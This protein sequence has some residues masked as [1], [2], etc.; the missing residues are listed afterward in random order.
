M[1]RQLTL[2]AFALV[3]IFF[4]LPNT[5]ASAAPAAPVDVI[6]TQPDG[7]TV[8]VRPFGDE[9]A[10][11]YETHDG[12]VVVPDRASGYWHY[13]EHDANQRFV[14]SGKRPGRDDPSGLSK[15][16][17]EKKKNRN[18]EAMSAAGTSGPA[19]AAGAP[20][21]LGFSALGSQKVLVI[22]AQFTDR[23]SVGSTP[24]D[25]SNAFFG[26]GNS[27]RRWY[28]EA[29]YGKF[30]FAPAETTGTAAPG[31]AGWVT[32]P[33]PHP[34]TGGSTDDRNRK[35]VADAI[36]AAN[37]YI[38]Y[39]AFDTNRNG[40]ISYNE[41]H[42]VVVVA[43]YETAYG[44]PASACQ[45]GIW[46]HRWGLGDTVLG[47]SVDGVVVGSYMGGGGYLQIG[48]WQCASY[49]N[50]GHMAT[51]GSSVHEL[52]H[53]IGWP[54]LYDVDGSTSGVGNWDI[55]AG[56]GWA[57]TTGYAGSLPTHPD[58]FLRWYQGWLTPSQL[59]GSA[60]GL[61]L[62]QVETNA[63]VVQLL[64]NP[65]GIDWVFGSRSGTGEYYLM[66]N[67]QKV[68]FDAGLPGAGM[69]IWHIDESVTSSNSANANENHRLVDVMQADGLRQL[70][71]TTGRGDAGDPYPGT[72]NN[73]SFTDTT[74]PS[75]RLYSGAAS[76]VSVTNI[77]NSG[78]TMSA[79]AS[80]PGTAST[81]TPT[82]T[83]PLTT[84]PTPTSTPTATP[85][86][87][88]ATTCPNGQYKAEYF[89]NVTMSGTPAL[90]RCESAPINYNWGNGSPAVGINADRFSVR[91]TGTFGFNA[92]SYNFSATADDGV[93]LLVDGVRI[94]DAWYDQPPT[95]YTASRNM[96]AGDYS[97]VVEYY[98]NLIGAVA[99]V[100][101]AQA[102][103]PTPT[104]TPTAPPATP[105][106]TSTSVS[107]PTPTA[108]PSPSPTAS[109]GSC[110]LGQYKAEYFNNMTL[111]GT[112]VL[113]RCESSIN[114]DWGAGSPAAGIPADRFSV[115]WTGQFSFTAG[116]RNF[117]ATADD[118]VR[119]SV[120]GSRLIE[121]WYDQGPT[122]YVTSRNMTAGTHTVMVEYYEDTGGAVAKV[123]W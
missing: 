65:G 120:D 111:S 31:V 86:A 54:D 104:A 57:R 28:E 35:I 22:L 51:I 39:A 121:A 56:G 20:G 101:W 15:H 119:L 87:P 33:Y 98:E 27:V 105:T 49:D 10:N 106:P 25:W 19:Q 13:A 109:A 64:D 94:I 69:L 52:G 85:T 102:A 6:L 96:T 7:T 92:G 68:G 71:T 48:E 2:V 108:S 38:N 12:Y 78:S 37:P 29:S 11:G 9:W 8:P 100:S 60:A 36:V 32:L 62:P 83:P 44:G 47:P 93:H 3:T 24:T 14:P 91:W 30:T 117:Y 110:T 59:N 123:S 74:N 66:E 113:T 103:V 43:G 118:G 26:S 89:N 70:N 76:G 53:D 5:S 21:P 42:I 72:S 116:S 17:R 58:P 90:T 115:R 45:P 34:N 95:T 122:T 23:K 67:R 46:A 80:A 84:S 16:L 82:A 77:S 81:P 55:M 73:R 97:I 63:N 79:D 61:S 4:W 107:T 99:K 40:Y 1:Q 18:N 41:L 50:P 112:P 114:Y 75:A 88:P